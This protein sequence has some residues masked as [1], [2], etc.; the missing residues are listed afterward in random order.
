ML[1]TIACFKWVIDEAD[2]KVDGGS[3]KLN[4][5]R[6][7]YKISAYDR[8][9][10]EEATRLQE[11]HGGTAGRRNGGRAERQAV[12]EGRPFPRA[13]SGAVR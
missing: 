9:A 10:I 8:N 3:R 1:K 2:I 7:A 6:V 5:E 13:G 12:S 11:Q 4:L